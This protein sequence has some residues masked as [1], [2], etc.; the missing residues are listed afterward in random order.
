MPMDIYIF[1]S[2]EGK[3]WTNRTAAQQQQGNQ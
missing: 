2:N 3:G 1:I